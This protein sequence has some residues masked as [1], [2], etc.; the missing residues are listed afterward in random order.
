[1][2]LAAS[3]KQRL[4]LPRI[5]MHLN[6]GGLQIVECAMSAKV[7]MT[8]A[9]GAMAD[10]ENTCFRCGVHI[11]LFEAIFIAMRGHRTILAQEGSPTGALAAHAQS[12]SM[13]IVWA[14]GKFAVWTSSIRP[15]RHLTAIRTSEANVAHAPPIQAQAIASAIIAAHAKLHEQCNLLTIGS[16]EAE[17][18]DTF[19]RIVGRPEGAF[20]MKTAAAWAVRILAI[21]PCPSLL[22]FAGTMFANSMITAIGRADGIAAS[23]RVGGIDRAPT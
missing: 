12:V 21:W 15:A 10:A 20:S 18:A 2:D 4:L 17:L 5:P 23:K 1:M 7:R 14:L 16:V 8:E 3:A 11:A 13:T 9:T 6:E 22:A 19:S